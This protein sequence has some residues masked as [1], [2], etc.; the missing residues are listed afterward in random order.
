MAHLILNNT[1]MGVP[2]VLTVYAITA[3]ESAGSSDVREL[4]N[5]KDKVIE[6]FF[7]FQL[8][9][10]VDRDCRYHCYD[11][12]WHQI[13]TSLSLMSWAM[14]VK[15]LELGP[16]IKGLGLLARWMLRESEA[17]EAAVEA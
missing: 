16:L 6:A 2:Q 12:Q 10:I 8:S 5:F 13:R 15:L 3:Q 11:M 1:L 9:R 7:N 4:V 17:D 14:S